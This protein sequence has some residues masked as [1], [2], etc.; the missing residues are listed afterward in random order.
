M[1]N[2]L[3]R[4]RSEY[5]KR[6]TAGTANPYTYENPA[7]MFH[8]QER[9]QGLIRMLR[10][11]G[12][13]LAAT[14]V[15]EIGCGTGH[16]LQRF[17]D[18][19]ARSALGVELMPHRIR[20]GQEQHPRV[21]MLCGDGGDL[22]LASGSFGLVAQFM[23]LSSVLD[24]SLRMR[25]A[26]E[27]WRVLAPGG[28]IIS[29]DLRPSSILCSSINHFAHYM[30]SAPAAPDAGA[31]KTPTRPVE[32]DEL[33]S[34]FP[35]ARVEAVTLSLNFNLAAI[36]RLSPLIASALSGIPA[37]RTHLLAVVRKPERINRG[38]P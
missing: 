31:V 11:Q 6:D 17:L 15:L 29:Y 14:D 26:A 25:I 28:L 20:M 30:Q 38:R 4:I 24:A 21:H 23:C 10:R 1:T 22:P 18:F 33:R 5:V 37:L 27:M 35:N 13:D 12:L 9:E 19:G 7:F 16:I 36:A 32:L 3:E 8:M 34:L 2:E